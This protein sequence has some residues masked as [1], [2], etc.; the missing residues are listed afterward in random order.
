[1]LKAEH[2]CLCDEL[3]HSSCFTLQFP[4]SDIYGLSCYFLLQD[5]NF[6]R[7][8]V[9]HSAMRKRE[10]QNQEHTACAIFLM[11]PNFQVLHREEKKP[12]KS[13]TLLYYTCMYL[14]SIRIYVL[15]KGTVFSNLSLNFFLPEREL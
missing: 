1:M 2:R 14:P 4:T 6:L 15:C 3:K 7:L 13:L 8:P 10:E 11:S 12:S 5:E 9:L